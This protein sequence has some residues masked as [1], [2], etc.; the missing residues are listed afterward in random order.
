MGID[1]LLYSD[2][3][4]P[5]PNRGITKKSSSLNTINE[6]ERYKSSHNSVRT[7]FNNKIITG[8]VSNDTFTDSRSSGN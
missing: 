4:M 1:I 3:S 5:P 7:L 2:Y 8:A 6:M